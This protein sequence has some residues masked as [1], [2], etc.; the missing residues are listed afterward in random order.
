MARNLWEE[1]EQEEFDSNSEYVQDN[2]F[3]VIPHDTRV[4]VIIDEATWKHKKNYKNKEKEEDCISLR[5]EIEDGEYKGQKL[6]KKFF[7][8]SDNEDQQLKDWKLFGFI[9]ALSGGKC[10]ALKRKA[11]DEEL[12]RFLINKTMVIIV[13]MMAGK[14]G[15]KDMNY[16]MGASSGKSKSTEKRETAQKAPT[17]TQSNNYADDSDNDVP[18]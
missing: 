12:S 16:V 8:E 5:F 6:F 13:G 11:T 10:L 18:F 14:N 4:K 15:Q 17:K 2:D 1:A 3:P 9:D 7:I